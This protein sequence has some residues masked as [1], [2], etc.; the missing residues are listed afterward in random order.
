MKMKSSS[1]GLASI[2]RLDIS[3]FHRPLYKALTPTAW[4]ILILVTVVT[5]LVV[6]EG[7]SFIKA[8][9][10]ATSYERPTIYVRNGIAVKAEDG[11][12][13]VMSINQAR[14]MKHHVVPVGYGVPNGPL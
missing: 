12:G 3:R 9:G 14:K 2:G 8:I 4:V 13:N 6:V 5:A 11:N 7:P 10:A 1:L